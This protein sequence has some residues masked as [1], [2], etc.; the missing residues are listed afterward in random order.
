MTRAA[1]Y[2]REDGCPE[3]VLTVDIDNRR[4]LRYMTE[5]VADSALM[6]LSASPPDDRVEHLVTDTAEALAYKR[7]VNYR[8]KYADGDK[9]TELRIANTDTDNHSY[10]ITQSVFFFL[11]QNRIP[12][13]GACSETCS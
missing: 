1:Q 9:M 6:V 12:I 5:H 7:A 3:L 2:A 10:F 11:V 8:E 13:R 4:A